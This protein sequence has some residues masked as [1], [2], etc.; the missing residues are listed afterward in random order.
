MKNQFLHI[1]FIIIIYINKI[2]LKYGKNIKSYI[3]Q[4]ILT[5]KKIEDMF[6]C[7]YE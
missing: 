1:R 4:V 6:N 3:S 7:S 5:T 2:F